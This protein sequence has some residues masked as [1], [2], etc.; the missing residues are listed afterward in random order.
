M[1]RKTIKLTY[2]NILLDAELNI[3]RWYHFSENAKIL[4]I[5]WN[6]Q[7]VRRFCEEREYI[8]FEATPSDLLED[9]YSVKHENTI[10]YVILMETIEVTERPALLLQKAF[11]CL[12]EDGKLLVI[13]NNKYAIKHFCGEKTPYEERLFDELEGQWAPNGSHSFGIGEFEKLF[14]DANI[15]HVQKYAVYPH[16]YNAKKIYSFEYAI[17]DRSDVYFQPWYVDNSRIFAHEEKM[18]PG[19]VA[20]GLFYAMANGFFFEASKKAEQSNAL[21]ITISSE[22]KAERQ[23]ITVVDG[24]GIVEK[25]PIYENGMNSIRLLEKNH[26]YLCDKGLHIVSGKVTEDSYQMEYLKMP[27]FLQQIE[28]I[29][30][31]GHGEIITL[32][33]KY[34]EEIRKSS[35]ITETTDL[36]EILQYGFIDLVP[37]NCFYENGKFLFFDQE[38]VIPNLPLKVI[39]Y[40]SLVLIY[41]AYPE[42]DFQ[43]PIT[44]FYDRYGITECIDDIRRIESE[45]LLELNVE[46]IM[47]L[48]K[49]YHVP[50]E[51]SIESNKDALNE[52]SLKRRLIENVLSN[53]ENKQII[54]FGVNEKAKEFIDNYRETC[55]IALIIDEDLT[56][57]GTIFEGY[58]IYAMDKLAELNQDEYKVI[59]FEGDVLPIYQRLSRWGAKDIGWYV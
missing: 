50:F 51:T 33:D 31:N 18:Y 48:H 37:I 6:N 54:L 7:L 9:D 39:I 1:K 30:Y 32:L 42:F 22:R 26:K 17:K 5:G 38:Y 47:I 40:R 53:L 20:S 44:F 11:S 28:K 45:W 19:L 10:D 3:L 56:K 13:A 12:K 43:I 16:L 2:D 21:F 4:A 59:I 58:D 14:Q 29:Y 23:F 8:F 46:D 49:D 27:T 25:S 35:V 55:E 24:N 57:K 15:N 52:A 41:E 36:G 34:V